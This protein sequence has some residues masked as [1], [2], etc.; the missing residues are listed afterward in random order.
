MSVKDRINSDLKAAL[1]G[2]DHFK[3]DVLR[4]IKAVILNEEVALGKREEGL[5]DSLVEQLIAKELKKRH[6]SAEIYN[7]A[8]RKEL[9]DKELNEVEILSQYLPPQLSEEEILKIIRSHASELS[10]KDQSGMGQLI[11]SV[12]KQLGSSADGSVIAKLV[13]QVVEENSK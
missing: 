1:L 8:D 3:C 7:Q 10:I 9:A 11:G 12:K 2:G 13:K 4:T 5:E 6:E